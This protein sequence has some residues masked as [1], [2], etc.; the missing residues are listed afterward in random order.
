MNV[1]R[2]INVSG[3]DGSGKTTVVEWLAEKLGEQG[4]DVDVR[5]LRFN[6]VFTKPL[7]AFCRLTGLT[8]YEYVN[9]I[10]VGYHEF[11]R[12]RVIAWL[13]VYLQYLDALRVRYLYLGKGAGNARKVILLDRYIYD[14]LIDLMIDTGIENLEKTHIG[15]AFLRLLPEGSLVLP[16]LRQEKKVL[17]A[18]PESRVDRNFSTRF[19]LYE[20]LPE[21]FGL[22]EVRNDLGLEE[23]LNTVA[24]KVGVGK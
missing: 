13:F 18:R 19:R 11:Y 16:I 22:S 10:R 21:K 6:H 5:W 24:E 20:N 7:L 12:S 1:P 9:G 23:L 4:Y 3:I 14:I 15:K 8:R 2:I 17:G